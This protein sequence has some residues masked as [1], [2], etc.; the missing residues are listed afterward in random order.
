QRSSLF[1]EL[2]GS[3]PGVAMRCNMAAVDHHPDLRLDPPGARARNG[4]IHPPE[5]GAQRAQTPPVQELERRRLDRGPLPRH[6]TPEAGELFDGSRWI[7]DVG[8]IRGDVMLALDAGGAACGF[9]H[10]SLRGSGDE[11]VELPVD[12]RG[13]RVLETLPDQRRGESGVDRNVLA[14]ESH[15]AHM[16]HV[17]VGE[18]HAVDAVYGAKL[19]VIAIASPQPRIVGRKIATIQALERWDE[20]H[21]EVVA[22]AERRAARLDE[23]LEEPSRGPEPHA[24]VEQPTVG[25][26]CDADAVPPDPAWGAAVDGDRQQRCYCASMRDTG[27]ISFQCLWF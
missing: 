6:P 25:G 21:A 16:V 12:A 19:R 14:Q 4:V 15:R 9:E 8:A 13:L 10:V 22:Q 20:A 17:A 23:L 3:R 11:V 24:E 27:W 2:L 7:R 18:Q 1:R 5:L 26:P